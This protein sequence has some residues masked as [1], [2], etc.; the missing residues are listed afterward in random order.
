MAFHSGIA[1][2]H[3]TVRLHNVTDCDL[4]AHYEIVT[5]WS[6]EGAPWLIPMPPEY[7]TPSVMLLERKWRTIFG[8][9][10]IQCT[11]EKFAGL[12]VASGGLLAQA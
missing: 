6:C 2:W 5:H 4:T 1:Q 10:F 9:I 3:F 7:P 8:A 11:K 12:D